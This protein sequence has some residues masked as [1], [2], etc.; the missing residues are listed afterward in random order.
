MTRMSREF[1]PGPAR[2]RHPD[3]RLLR[4]PVPR[5]GAGEEGRRAGRQ[6]GR[7]T[8][9]THPLPPHAA[10]RSSCSSTAPATPA[11]STAGPR[12][13]PASPAAGSA[14]PAAPS[15]PAGA[16]P[17]HRQP[18]D[19]PPRLAEAGRGATASTST[20]STANRTGTSPPATSSPS[21]DRHPRTGHLRPAR[22]VPGARPA[23][24]RRADVR[25]VPHPAASSRTWSSAAGRRTS[26]S[27]YGRFDLAFDGVDPPKLLEYNAD[28]P[29][30]LLEAAVVQ[31]DWLKDAD[32]G[33]RPVQQ[34]PRAADRGL[35]RRPRAATTARSTSPP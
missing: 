23:R 5:R 7:R 32:A 2:G 12:P 13:C 11:S 20:P 16:D 9:D 26:R 35:A 15:A 22:D 17:M 1:S 14:A 8:T 18:L 27:I 19:A 24:H 29:T 4:R 33:R 25:P 6:A 34:H 30:A 3:G 10:S 31:W 21:R 28:T